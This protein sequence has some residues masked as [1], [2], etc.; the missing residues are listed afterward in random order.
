MNQEHDYFC[1]QYNAAPIVV[2]KGEGIYVWDVNGER[3]LDALCGIGAC[4]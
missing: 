3:Y 2:E 4:N 1:R